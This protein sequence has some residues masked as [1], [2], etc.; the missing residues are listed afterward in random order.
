M[1]IVSEHFIA[2]L[3]YQSAFSFASSCDLLPF[4]EMIRKFGRHFEALSIGDH[5]IAYQ[6]VRIAARTRPDSK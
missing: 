1:H 3:L 6:L 5:S 2:I 4:A